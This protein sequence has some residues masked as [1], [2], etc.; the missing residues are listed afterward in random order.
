M[1]LAGGLILVAALAYFGF[2]GINDVGLPP[3]TGTAVVIG[4]EHVPSK[5]TYR[6]D[7]IAGRP[8]VIPQFVPEMY[9][10]KLRLGNTES[11]AAVDQSLY[12]ATNNGDQVAVTYQETRLT[13][14]L[15]ITGVRSGVH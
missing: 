7:Y 2:Q 8:R 1:P 6:T 10:L 5:K 4:K 3:K 12:E 11:S 15:Q 14:K 9:V 13:G